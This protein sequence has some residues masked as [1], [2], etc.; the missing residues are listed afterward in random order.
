MGDLNTAIA[1]LERQVNKAN[2][3]DM[4]LHERHEKAIAK[5]AHLQTTNWLAQRGRVGGEICKVS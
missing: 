5:T 3:L 1:E 4:Q 2:W